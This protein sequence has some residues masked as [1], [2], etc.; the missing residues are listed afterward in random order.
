MPPAAEK[1]IVTNL[2]YN[3]AKARGAESELESLESGF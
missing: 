1:K 3:T 2:Q